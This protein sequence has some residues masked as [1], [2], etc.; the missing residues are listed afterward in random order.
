MH[1]GER[2]GLL[3]HQEDRGYFPTTKDI[4]SRSWVP[5]YTMH[6]SIGQDRIAVTPIANRGD[7][8]GRGQWRNSFLAAHCFANRGLRELTLPTQ[9]F[10]GGR[11]RDNLG[12]SD[13]NLHIVHQAMLADVETPEGTGHDAAVPGMHIAG[14][15]GTAEVENSSGHVD[16]GLKITWFASFAPVENPR[17]AVVAMVVSGA[18]G[19]LTCAPLAHKVYVA[20]DEKDKKVLAK[21]G[22]VAA[23]Q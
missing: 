5:G 13:R 15:T 17:Y 12:V 21:S 8:F 11:V 4:A 2:T 9:S 7:D 16:K 6:L 18:S 22:I 10:P 14:K 20:I 19:G 3:Q 23:S 1:F